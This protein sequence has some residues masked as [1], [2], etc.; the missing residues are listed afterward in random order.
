MSHQFRYRLDIKL[1]VQLQESICSFIQSIFIVICS[2]EFKFLADTPHG[3]LHL[4]R[5]YC[6]CIQHN[7]RDFCHLNYIDI[8]AL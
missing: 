4:R 7:S 2:D 6:S 3:F 5:D 1:L 8:P